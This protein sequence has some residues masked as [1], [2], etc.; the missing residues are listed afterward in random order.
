MLRGNRLSARDRCQLAALDDEHDDRRDRDDDEQDAEHRFLV[1]Q[2]VQRLVPPGT[3]PIGRLVVVPLAAACS[4][5]HLLIA[6]G[7]GAEVNA[8]RTYRDAAGARAQ[9]WLIPEA[10]HTGGLKSRPAEYERRTI[11]FLDD[12][13]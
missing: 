11:G 10:A 1:A 8:N 2:G 7:H 12:V 6:S 9:L 13:I 3:G 5:L 4:Q